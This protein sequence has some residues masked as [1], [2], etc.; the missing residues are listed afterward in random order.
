MSAAWLLHAAAQP[1]PPRLLTL[2]EVLAASRDNPD[3]MLARQSLAA[4]RA[5]VLAADHAPAPQ[6]TGKLSSIDLQNGV[7]AGS[8]GRKRI[9]SSLGIDWTWERGGKRRARTTAAERAADAA[10]ADLDDTQVQQLIAAGSAFYELLG[11]QE[12]IA[13]VEAIHRS[14]A[15]LAAAA[16]RRVQAGDLA[17]QEAARTAIEAQ[18]SDVELRAAEL[19]RQRAQ[20]ELTRLLGPAAA[21]SGLAASPDWPA[22][23]LHA[24]GTDIDALIE[25]RADVRAARERVASTDAALAAAQ[26]QRSADVTWGVSVDHFP[27]TSN[28][29]LEVRATMPLN[30]GYGFEGEIGRAQAQHA[31]AQETLAR[32]RHDAGLELQRLREEA[33]VDARRLQSFEADILLRAR[34]V[35][36]SAELAYRKGAMSLTDLLD[37]R[38]TLRATQLDAIAARIDHAKASLAWRLRTQPPSMP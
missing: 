8:F 4:A 37:A 14:A 28:R 32:A 30:W 27:G 17:A 1:A 12:R 31:Q 7:G 6:L 11:A 34:Q 16:A 36:D 19:E 38:R 13:E 29:L 9:D 35:A 26:A 10:A 15:Q 21:V 23:A 22:L 2:N 25:Q 18:R 20:L 33:L 24:E 3:V 5:D